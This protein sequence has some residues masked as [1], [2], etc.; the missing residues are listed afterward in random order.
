MHG[1]LQRGLPAALA[2]AAAVASVGGLRTV[3][4]KTS[5]AL[6]IDE[7]GKP[8]DV[9]RLESQPLRELGEH[10]VLINILAVRAW[11]Q[12]GPGGAGGCAARRA[13]RCWQCAVD[14]PVGRCIPAQL[15]EL[16]GKVQR[17]AC[18]AR[19][20]GS[21]PPHRAAL[22]LPAHTLLCRP[23]RASPHTKPSTH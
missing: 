6:V 10:E 23:C 5:K 3:F 1:L 19:T 22:P 20:V 4:S 21:L 18:S 14:L 16:Q 12:A 11:G 15:S 13:G 9:L 17:L 2:R 8:E 7:F